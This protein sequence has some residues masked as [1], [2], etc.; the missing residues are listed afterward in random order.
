MLCAIRSSVSPSF[1]AQLLEQ[2]QHR[3]LH[4]HVE[5]GDGLVGDEHLGLERERARDAHALAL[6][7]RELTRV[8][9]ERP[10]AEADEV[11]QLAAARVDLRL[12]DHLVR[13]QQLGQ[14]LL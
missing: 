2:V 12:R 11:E 5:G 13:A 14:H 10:R 6:A 1:S 7:A 4:R 9:V 8:G 3:R